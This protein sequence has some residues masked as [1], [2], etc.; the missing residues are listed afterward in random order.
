MLPTSAI[1]LISCLS[2]NM[3]AN[4]YTKIIN[5]LQ[6]CQCIL[7]NDGQAENS[8]INE[9]IKHYIEVRSPLIAELGV[10]ADSLRSRLLAMTP[11]QRITLFKN[12]RL[13]DQAIDHYR[14][15]ISSMVNWDYPSL[16]IFPGDGVC[17]H[18]LL[19]A[20]PLYIVD[21]NQEI[22][23]HVGAQFNEFFNQ[24]RLIKYTI[25]EFDL[26]VLPQASFGLIVCANW[27]RFE[28]IRGLTDLAKAV[29]DCLMPG[30]NFLFS[31]NSN[32][33]W[34]GVN[35][36]EQGYSH[37]VDS[38]NLHTALQKIGFE[39]IQDCQSDWDLNHVLIKKP[40]T[41]TP[42]KA[43]SVLGKYI[44]RPHDIK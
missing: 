38:E 1:L 41:I 26:S 35:N 27:L 6:N 40:G 24:K 17:T 43:G 30:G 25:K 9:L 28:N 23:D 5:Y 39:L 4:E 8:A 42:I 21:W 37:G 20:E 13:S 19:G 29:Y 32:S 22:L 3:K 34:W 18:Q 2:F 44:D 15:V 16:E 12:W 31:Y 36:M 14:N 7:R 33:T 10:A 11:A